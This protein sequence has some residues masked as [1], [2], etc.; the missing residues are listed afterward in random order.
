M[1]NI[2]YIATSLDGYISSPD[3]K[4]D[5]LETVPNPTG[6]DLGF[7]EF[8]A[9]VDAV[10]MGRVTFET[11]QGFGMGWGYPVPGIILS[12]TQKNP[13]DA[14]AEKVQFLNASPADVVAAAAAQGFEHLYID[15]GKTI[16]GF[17]REGLI[18]EMII[19]EIPIILGG[20]DRLFG[21]LVEPQQFEFVG[22]EVLLGQLLKKRYV[23]I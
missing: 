12:A 7:N 11:V 2:V 22:S 9:R 1:S 16:Q 17:L 3:G 6:D 23:R 4:L 5:W 18:D 19:T 21:D 8:M 14:F 13:P 10:V 20:G 15:G